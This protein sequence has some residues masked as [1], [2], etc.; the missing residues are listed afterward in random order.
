[1]HN[2]I[3]VR[4]FVYSLARSQPM[5]KHTV[6]SLSYFFYPQRFMSTLLA[7]CGRPA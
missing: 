5:L 3:I 1:M 2:E 6:P 7:V 4:L